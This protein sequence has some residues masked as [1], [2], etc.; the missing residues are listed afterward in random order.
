[1][2]GAN[3]PYLPRHNLLFAA[4]YRWSDS[5][6]H[7]RGSEEQ[8]QRFANNN[9]VVNRQRI[10]DLSG[11]YQTSKQDSISLSVPIMVDAS[12]SIPRPLGP[13]AGQR[14]VQH[15]SGL[16]DIVFTYR[17]WVLDTERAKHGNY[18][19]GLGVKFPTGD[20][21]AESPFPDNNGQNV[22]MRPVD[23]SI[24][25]GTGGWGLLMELQGFKQFGD[26]TGFVQGVY[27]AEPK[28]TTG[29]MRSST[30]GFTQFNS[31]ADQYMARFGAMIPIKPVKGLTFSIGARVEGV[32]SSDFIG[33]DEGFRRPGHA[34]SIEPGLIWSQGR[35]TY[36][37]FMP[38]A[39]ERRREANAI[40]AMGDATFADF[41]FLIGFSHR[42]GK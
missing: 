1:V 8:F 38:W 3:G 14:F 29:V 12:W 20:P 9:N 18:G 35:D 16:S 26:V 4:T 19:I 30:V 6:R 32:P 10:L 23:W 42:F 5:M 17:H 13:P 36:S 11:T 22:I 40:G 2:F 33:G 21:H 39:I 28:A 27:L 34:V 24:Q 7:F 31:A 15:A 37:F 25:P 41:F